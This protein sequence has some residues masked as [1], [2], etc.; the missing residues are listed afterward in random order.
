NL[1]GNAIKFTER[2]TVTLRLVSRPAGANGRMLMTFEVE[3][4]GIGIAPE[5][6]SRIF[7][8]FVQAGQQRNQKGTGLGLTISRQFVELMGGTIHVG[9]APGTGSRFRVELPVD[10][11]EDSQLKRPEPVEEQIVGVDP[12]RSGYRILIVEDREENWLVLQ[13][14]MQKTGFEVR[15]AED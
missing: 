10:A 15:I 14:L 8:A 11:V 12:G 3:D 9:S 7:D 6:Q 5:D 13:R 1:L 2:G 4:T